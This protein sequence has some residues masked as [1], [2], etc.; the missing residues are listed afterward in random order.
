MTLAYPWLLLLVLIIPLLL[1]LRYYPRRRPTLTFS[2]TSTFSSLP[3]SLAS[4]MLILLPILYGL[5]LFFLIA[6]IARPQIGLEQS[7]VKTE[8]VDIILLVDVSTSMRA[9]DFATSTD[10]HR[11]R[12]DAAKEVISKFVTDRREDRIGMVAFAAMPYT[13]SPLTL[14][15]GWL[16]RRMQ[17]LRT[18]MLED[19]TAIGDA[20]ASGVN[21]LRESKAKSKVIILLT[22]GINNAG[23]VTPENAAQAAKA[24]GIKIYTVAAGSTGLVNIPVQTPFGGVQYVQEQS[25]IDVTKLVS[26][27]KITGAMFFQAKDY[28]Q[29]E[30]I[31]KQIDQME[32]TKVEVEQYTRFEEKFMPFLVIALILLA[33]EKAL[34]L[35]RLGRLP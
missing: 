23:V 1:F 26:I 24:L 9:E 11:N 5:G 29:L 32:K 18:G 8:A 33:A 10:I 13:V 19:G 22:D 34:S 30:K 31:Y 16:L 20:I 2:D 12:L 17:D 21:R 4:R 25:D 7:K 28:K 14:D 15:H 3:K 27:S 6:A 35:S